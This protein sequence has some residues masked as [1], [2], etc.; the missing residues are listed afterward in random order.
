M[1]KLKLASSKSLLKDVCVWS[2]LPLVAAVSFS[3]LVSCKLN[4]SITYW[5][6]ALVNA[7]HTVDAN[8]GKWPIEGHSCRVIRRITLL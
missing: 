6:P 1:L 8:Y 2:S 7:N 4:L 5:L 3:A